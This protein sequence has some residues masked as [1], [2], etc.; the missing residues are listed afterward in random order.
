MRTG[1]MLFFFLAGM[2]LLAMGAEP[3]TVEIPSIS[4]VLPEDADAVHQRL[5]RVFESQLYQRC[6]ARVERGLEGDIVVELVLGSGGAEDGYTI[7]D[8]P[9]GGILISGGNLP[10]LLYG[11]GKF[12]P[13]STYE[14]GEGKR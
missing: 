3:M 8:R 1:K 12:L 13:S 2:P 10:G 6:G 5:A 9:K 14:D 11:V 4:L 7:G